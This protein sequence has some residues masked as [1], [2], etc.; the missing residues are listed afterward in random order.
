MISKTI[1][2]IWL[3]DDPL[4]EGAAKCINSWKKQAP[5]FEIRRWKLSDFESV[6]L[7]LFVKQALEKKKWAFACDYLRAY[8]LYHEGGIYLDSDVF[9]I[10]DIAPY[11]NHDF[12]SSIEYFEELFDEEE[13]KHIDKEGDSDKEFVKG[14]AVNAAM[15]ASVKGHPFLKD[16][17]NYYE[18]IDFI[19]EDGNLK[20]DVVAPQ[21]YS[22]IARE[23][24]FKYQNKEQ[25]L[26]DDIYLYSSEVFAKSFGGT[27]PD[28]ALVHMCAASWR[29]NSKEYM[30]LYHW[31]QLNQLTYLENR[32]WSRPYLS[33]IVLCYKV[34]DYLTQCLESIRRQTFKDFEVIMVDD[35]SPDACGAICD[36]YY[37]MDSRF[38][39][40]HKENGGIIAAR[41]DALNMARGYWAGS[42]DGDDWIS[43]DMYK[44]MWETQC[45]YNTDITQVRYLIHQPEHAYDYF[46]KSNNPITYYD[47]ETYNRNL[48]DEKYFKNHF[49]EVSLCRSII[50]TDRLRTIMNKLDNNCSL[51][52]DAICMYVYAA[53][54]YSLCTINKGLY[55][56]R[57]R[58]NSCTTSLKSRDV[59]GLYKLFS[60]AETEL[61]GKKLGVSLIK[62]LAL[63]FVQ[64]LITSFLM[65][66]SE[67]SD[68][69]E[70]FNNYLDDK[71]FKNIL[72]KV[73]AKEVEDHFNDFR[74]DLIYRKEGYEK[75]I[76]ESKSDKY[77]NF[78]K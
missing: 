3:S 74:I 16:V 45:S 24:G 10:K 57:M 20:T 49:I 18:S 50:R 53:D 69:V 72:G 30:N 28:S 78:F 34:A 77:A 67:K 4:T 38:K 52:E 14:L 71:R 46:Q 29:D 60:F 13:Q 5:E 51:C 56:Y 63:Y 55:K 54:S 1:H 2:Y 40:I 43:L 6:E 70:K 66:V 8:V 58:N 75:I 19:N 21:I 37:R 36:A 32:D 59:E 39:V 23:Y 76:L 41:K 26:N 62:Q 65:N 12:V 47:K 22:L 48:T 25:L 11:L 64:H 61:E 9:M 68:A 17:L 27:T 33:I 31:I 15:M 73:P 35:G 44:S 42:V 7:P